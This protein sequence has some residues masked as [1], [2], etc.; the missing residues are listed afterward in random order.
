MKNFQ[1][2]GVKSAKGEG[3]FW[4]LSVV[5]SALIER[6]GKIGDKGK[7]KKTDCAD[8]PTAHAQAEKL[9]AEKRAAGFLLMPVKA[10][11]DTNETLPAAQATGQ[12]AVHAP[13]PVEW[14]ALETQF[15]HICECIDERYRE[16]LIDAFGPRFKGGAWAWDPVTEDR[17]HHEID[18]LGDV[19]MGPLFTS[20]AYEWPCRDG[21]PMAPLLQ[22]DLERAS[23]LGGVA[24]GH[25]LVQVWMPHKAVDGQ[26]Q[27]VRVVPRRSVDRSALTPVPA[28]PSE[29]DPLQKLDWIW[30]EKLGRSEPP[31][32]FQI[33]AWGNRRYT[34]PVAQGLQSHYKLKLLTSDPAL[35]KEIEGFDH[36]LATLV[37]G[38]CA[39]FSSANTH[40]FGTFSEIQY[41]VQDRPQPLFCFDDEAFGLV[42]G[43]GGNSQLFYALGAKGEVIFS[44]DWS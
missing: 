6:E 15:H 19:V 44:F 42:W 26:E 4:E 17:P 31:P 18:R 20:Q 1:Q 23:H 5:G 9:I 40:L 13:A 25:G 8:R 21:L 37:Q 14:L 33:V 32:A 27:F 29:L 39:R 2:Y 36:A 7:Q 35:A 34:T 12:S 11:P 16:E 38:P 22:L 43:D 24:L 10:L 41:A 3:R 28:M 30:N